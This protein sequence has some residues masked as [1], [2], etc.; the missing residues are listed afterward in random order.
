MYENIDIKN[1]DIIPNGVDL[2][3]FKP[4]NKNRCLEKVRWD[5]NKKHIL[6]AANPNRLEKN[7]MLANNAF[8][9]LNRNDI[10]LHTM[11]N[12]DHKMVPYYMNAADVVILTS[13][14]EGSPNV[15]KEAMAC[16]RPIV[17]T[18][19]GDVRNIVDKTNG[20]YICTNNSNDISQKI[21][22]ALNF[23]E[24]NGRLNISHLDKNEVAKKIG[25]I[26]KKII[27]ER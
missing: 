25:N 13:L 10:E 17:S 14:W 16:N 4:M 24:T 3:V 19:V 11:I 23:K 21:S 2:S 26:Y 18:D 1:I 15:I 5:K 12:I 9:A 20:C 7:F 27:S 22:F 8:E 6:F